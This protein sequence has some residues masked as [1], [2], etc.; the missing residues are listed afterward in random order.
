MAR[1]KDGIGY[2]QPPKHSRFRKGRSGNPKGRPKGS[3][4]LRTLLDRELDVKVV[5]TDN[6]KR[7]TISKREAVAKRMVN[8]AISGEL[9]A[10]KTVVSLV[11][12]DDDPTKGTGLRELEIGPDDLE[13]VKAF[14]ERQ[15]QLKN[16]C[17]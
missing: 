16:G 13:V 15:L 3:K 12:G 14:L 6:G 10:T 5:V 17:E 2:G 7:K 8:N 11:D 1:D 4:K 9:N